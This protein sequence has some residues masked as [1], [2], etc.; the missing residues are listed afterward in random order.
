MFECPGPAECDREISGLAAREL[1]GKDN[2]GSLRKCGAS[3]QEHQDNQ[4]HPRSPTALGKAAR[5]AWQIATANASDASK[6]GTQGPRDKVAMHHHLDLLFLGAAI[7]GNTHLDCQRRILANRKMS[8]GSQQQNHTTNMRQLQCG[9]RIY[10][11]RHFLH[12]HNIRS[13]RV[14][15]AAQNS[16]AICA[17]RMAKL[18]R[19]TRTDHARIHQIVTSPIGFDQPIA[20]PL[21][22]T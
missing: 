17:S 16:P 10:R 6:D 14:K 1:F 21:R 7:T 8:L 18:I 9:F 2:P 19:N 11:V 12:R 4:I 22:A 3:N 20:G 15:N 5:V 13:M